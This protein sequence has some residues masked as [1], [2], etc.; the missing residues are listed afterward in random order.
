MITF[1]FIMDISDIIE[2]AKAQRQA[3]LAA[4]KRRE[5]ILEQIRALR[6]ELSDLPEPEDPDV[7]PAWQSE[8]MERIKIT[9]TS[10]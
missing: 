5:E 9:I 4:N 1:H 3:S 2:K 10:H 8:L 6:R 7:I